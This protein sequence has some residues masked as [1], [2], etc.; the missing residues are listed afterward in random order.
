MKSVAAC[1]VGEAR[2][3]SLP[4][5]YTALGRHVIDPLDADVFLVVSRAWSA[6]PDSRFGRGSRS[7]T[8]P[9]TADL[10]AAVA[11]LQPRRSIIDEESAELFGGAEQFEQAANILYPKCTKDENSTHGRYVSIGCRAQTAYVARMRLCLMLIEQEE[12]VDVAASGR[13]GQQYEWVLRSRPDIY[14]SCM[15]KHSITRA[16]T[17]TDKAGSTNRL[18][19]FQSDLFALLPRAAASTSLRQLVLSRS[20]AWCAGWDQPKASNGLWEYCNACIVK[21]LWPVTMLTISGLEVVRK[22]QLL[23]DEK[24][25]RPC[26][27]ADPYVQA[28]AL[29]HNHTARTCAPHLWDTFTMRHV[30]T[31]RRSCG[32]ERLI[33]DA[34]RSALRSLERAVLEIGRGLQQ[35]QHG[36]SRLPRV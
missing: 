26:R 23:S 19:A 32:K 10:A 18:S 33:D 2:T 6:S 15:Q 24:L 16:L 5:V 27:T 22:C 13:K 20:E 14:S 29:L 11:A 30:Q 3:L 4:A 34:T 31:P 9:P 28:N 1:F 12:S 25:G 35:R 7:S 21:R 8:S 17:Y 36:A